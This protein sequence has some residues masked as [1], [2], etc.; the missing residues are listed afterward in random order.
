MVPLLIGLPVLWC[1][2]TP[3]IDCFIKFSKKLKN[4][5]NF[6]FSDTLFF[7]SLS[8]SSL[9]ISGVGF[10]LLLSFRYFLYTFSIP[11][12]IFLIRWL[13]SGNCGYCFI[14]FALWVSVFQY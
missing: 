5:F 9:N 1:L 13:N 11:V 10:S 3:S 14:C 12:M 6:S 8:S 7:I 4:E 2:L